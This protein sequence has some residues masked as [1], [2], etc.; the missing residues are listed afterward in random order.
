[1]INLFKNEEPKKARRVYRVENLNSDK[2]ISSSMKVA[3]D[4]HR[5]TVCLCMPHKVVYTTFLNEFS[6]LE[7]MKKYKKQ[8]KSLKSNK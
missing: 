4:G 5:Y 6:A 3:E 2:G 7:Q 8:Y 1:M